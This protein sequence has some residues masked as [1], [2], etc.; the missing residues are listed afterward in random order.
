MR[1]LAD[2]VQLRIISELQKGNVSPSDFAATT[3]VDLGYISRSFRRLSDLGY[4]E[5]VEERRAL[6]GGASVERLYQAVDRPRL[7][8][9]PLELSSPAW[10][11]ASHPV[12]ARLFRLATEALGAG[13]FDAEPDSVWAYDTKALE[14]DAWLELRRLLGDLDRRLPTL[15]AEARRRLLA[16]DSEPML[17]A[18]GMTA[19]ESPRPPF[20]SPQPPEL[21]IQPERMVR[22]ENVSFLSQPTVAPEM[23]KGLSNRWRSRILMELAVRPMSP[24]RFAEE[25]GGESSYIARCFREL[26]EWGLIEVAEERKGGLRGGGVERIYRG[27]R[28][29]HFDDAAWQLLPHSLRRDVSASMLSNYMSRMGEAVA[30]GTLDSGGG[31]HLSCR[32][33][34]VD[35]QAW[36]AI[37]ARIGEIFDRLPT[38]EE[39]SVSRNGGAVDGLVPTL[40]GLVFF[41]L[42]G[43][44]C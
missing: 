2:P 7:A 27:A 21:L 41:R 24:S 29:P 8:A 26:G 22:N 10:P 12:L 28:Y 39:E 32:L 19:F 40:V 13:T 44:G 1:V 11:V 37:R 35:H 34:V 15:E 16:G 18:V 17:T 4:A 42:P 33:L 6:R 5:V 31:G 36:T 9:T 25:V 14:M 23:A 30:A 43:G 38:L 3:G 20:L